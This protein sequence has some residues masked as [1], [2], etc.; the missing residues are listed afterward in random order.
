[1]PS[2]IRKAAVAGSWYPGSAQALAAAVDRYVD[3]ADDGGRELTKLVALVAPSGAVAI[4]GRSPFQR[5]LACDGV[6]RMQWPIPLVDSPNGPL[7]D[8]DR[9]S[10]AVPDGV[11]D[12]P[13]SSGVLHPMTRGTLNSPASNDGSGAAA[14]AASRSS[15]GRTWSSRSESCRLRT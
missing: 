2:A 7:A 13:N 8:F 14:S 15:D 12:L 11:A 1:M 3:A 9:Q 6:E 4:D 10:F 5:L